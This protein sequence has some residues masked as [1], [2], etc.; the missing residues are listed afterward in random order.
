MEAA[1]MEAYSSSK[2]LLTHLPICR[3][4][5]FPK[6]RIHH[7]RI[8]A[9][10]SIKIIIVFTILKPLLTSYIFLLPARAVLF[11]EKYV[12]TI[13]DGLIRKIK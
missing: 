8:P 5:S 10:S 7:N 12:I 9:H 11:P 13:I 6:I 1:V 3:G 2:P 4:F